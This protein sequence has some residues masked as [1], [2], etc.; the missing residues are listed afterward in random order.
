[1][2]WKFGQQQRWKLKQADY[3]VSLLAKKTKQKNKF[4]AV[5]NKWNIYILDK[6][7]TS[8]YLLFDIDIVHDS[9]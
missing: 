4:G 2:L 6:E 7:K 8:C 9:P 1:M 3:R 5:L